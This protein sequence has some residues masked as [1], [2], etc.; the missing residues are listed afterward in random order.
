MNAG[1]DRSMERQ[2]AMY[3]FREIVDW[4]GEKW[5]NAAVQRTKS[6]PIE[7][8]TQG[9]LITLAKL[10]AKKG[11]ESR[12]L[13]GLAARWLVDKAPT[14]PW[15]GKVRG[16]RPEER[17]FNLCSNAD[18]SNYQW[19]QTEAL[20]L[21]DLLK[22]M[23]G[24][25]YGEALLNDIHFESIASMDVTAGIFEEVRAG[26]VLREVLKWDSGIGES[27]ATRAKSLPMEIQAYG[28]LVTLSN[29]LRAQGR[30][31]FELARII[32]AWLLKAAPRK[33]LAEGLEKEPLLQSLFSLCITMDADVYQAFQSE[34]LI[35]AELI[36]AYATAL[37]NP[38][39]EA[40]LSAK[41]GDMQ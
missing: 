1:H 8:R 7:L 26:F 40:F 30:S 31:H 6:L 5:K 23:A 22:L 25:F 11:G 34:A 29:L 10:K 3:L 33:P 28:L 17:L 32:A 19:A 20:A 18:R 13:L 24:A 9:L 36:K 16:G 4:Q 39:G 21:L 41:A 35:L 27:A 2:R 38:K 37:H 14:R 12:R 15:S